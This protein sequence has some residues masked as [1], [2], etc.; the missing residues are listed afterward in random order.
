MEENDIINLLGRLYFM[1]EATA[2]IIGDHG[3][4]TF[5]QLC[6]LDNTDC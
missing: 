1:A 6:D 5:D 3:L 4:S 2:L